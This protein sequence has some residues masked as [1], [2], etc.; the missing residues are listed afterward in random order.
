M[1]RKRKKCKRKKEKLK[2]DGSFVQSIILHAANLRLCDKR[3]KRDSRLHHVIYIRLSFSCWPNRIPFWCRNFQVAMRTTR[4]NESKRKKK[5]LNQNTANE[6]KITS[7][8]D[9]CN[10][11]H[12]CWQRNRLRSTINATNYFLDSQRGNQL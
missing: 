11:A 2:L 8:V 4:N 12:Y 9:I 7:S 1:K 5:S 10:G 6:R 3:W